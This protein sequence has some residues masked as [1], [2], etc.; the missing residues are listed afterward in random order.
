MGWLLQE[1]VSELGELNNEDLK[2]LGV[3]LGDRKKIL[4]RDAGGVTSP[5]GNG[6]GAR[7]V[8]VAAAMACG[9]CM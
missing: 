1:N 9:S 3:K 2:E 4:A 5:W 7:C 8:C 6:P